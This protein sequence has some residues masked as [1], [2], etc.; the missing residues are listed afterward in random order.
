M[1]LQ[2]QSQ[3]S[4]VVDSIE[5]WYRPR[6]R[7]LLL[8]GFD[9]PLSSAANTKMLSDTIVQ[10][11]RRHSSGVIAFADIR[12]RWRETLTTMEIAAHW[13]LRPFFSVLELVVISLLVLLIVELLRE[14][15]SRPDTRDY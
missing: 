6:A 8:R 14:H 5:R 12:D 3:Q 10:S 11:T 4:Y 13:L 15:L 7:L 1:H 2:P 9:E